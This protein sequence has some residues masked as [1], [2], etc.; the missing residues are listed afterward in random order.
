MKNLVEKITGFARG[1]DSI[2][3]LFYVEWLVIVG[4]FVLLFAGSTYGLQFLKITGFILGVVFP[5]IIGIII[6]RSLLVLCL[7]SRATRIQREIEDEIRQFILQGLP[8]V[9]PGISS[10]KIHLIFREFDTL[11]SHRA[12]GKDE[13]LAYL[14]RL[15]AGE[16]VPSDAPEE[17]GSGTGELKKEA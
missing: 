6:L 13:H 14:E 1:E 5:F 12:E 15:T 2:W 17:S 16:A 3:D 8:N 11:M 9:V 7:N 4:L 10:D